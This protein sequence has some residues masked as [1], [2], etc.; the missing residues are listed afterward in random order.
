M[1]DDDEDIFHPGCPV[2]GHQRAVTQVEFSGGGV[3]VS[4]GEDKWVR[5]W[6]IASGEQMRQLAG[7][8]FALVDCPDEEHRTYLYVLTADDDTLRIYKVATN[9]LSL[10]AEYGL[11]FSLSLTH[12][13]SLSFTL[14]LIPAHSHSLTPTH[15]HSLTPTRS[16][17]LG[18]HSHSLSLSLT[19]THA[20]LL[21]LTHS[22]LLSLS[23]TLTHPH[24]GAAGA[25]VACFKAPQRI[26]SL[27]CHGAAICVGCIGGAVCILRAP[28]L[29]I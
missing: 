14:S 12:S 3:I 5:V 25:P 1:D 24:L 4:C 22:H 23:L 28:F 19:L 20:H 16:H 13:N 17:S 10:M 9:T 2:L 6:D 21:T 26:T 15:S 27:Q 18:T 7:E 29:G 8:M 11:T